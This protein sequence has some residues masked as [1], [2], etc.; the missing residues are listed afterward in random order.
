[1]SACHGDILR[2]DIV[3]NAPL[4]G[5]GAWQRNQWPLETSRDREALQIAGWITVEE[6][7]VLHASRLN[8][9]GRVKEERIG[10]PSEKYRVIQGTYSAY[11]Q[12]Q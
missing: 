11:T 1:L 7:E 3:E 9:H 12:K 6:G 5:E 4:D 8:A 10:S 2:I